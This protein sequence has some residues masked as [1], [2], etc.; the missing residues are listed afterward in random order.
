MKAQVLQWGQSGGKKV[1]T[2]MANGRLWQ[3]A[4]AGGSVKGKR[5]VC[6]QT[7]SAREVAIVEMA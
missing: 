6:V 4:V 5:C 2:G 3:E 1:E 7:V